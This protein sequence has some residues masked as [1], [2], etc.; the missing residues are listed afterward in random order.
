MCLPH[1]ICFTNI[2]ASRRSYSTVLLKGH[3]KRVAPGGPPRNSQQAPPTLMTKL[4]YK[5]MSRCDCFLQEQHLWFGKRTTYCYWHGHCFGFEKEPCPV[6]GGSTVLCL[7]SADTPSP[8]VW[9]YNSHYNTPNLVRVTL[10]YSPVCTCTD[11]RIIHLGTK[12]QGRPYRTWVCVITH[13]PDTMLNYAGAGRNS[14]HTT[15]E[16][17]TLDKTQHMCMSVFINV[18]APVCEY[19]ASCSI[20]PGWRKERLCWRT[21]DVPMAH[22]LAFQN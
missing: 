1:H 13:L 18:F 17:C 14:T 3:W 11:E 22:A 12:Q 8:F 7:N 21:C 16:W 10:G 20:Q 15:A 6:F 19:P 9:S 4:L 2:W 5:N